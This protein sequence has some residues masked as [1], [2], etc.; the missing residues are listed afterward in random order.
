[1]STKSVSEVIDQDRRQL[2]TNAAMGIAAAGA[3]SIFPA[4]R[5]NA[6]AE[7]RNPSVPR[8]FSGR[9]AGR[10]AQTCK[11]D[12]VAQPGKRQGCNA[13]RAIR[14][15]AEA[16]TVLGD[17]LRLAQD[18]VQAECVAAVHHRDRWDRHSFHSYPLEARECFA[19]GRHAWMAGF[20]HRAIEDYRS[21]Y[22]SQRR[23]ARA[24]R[25]PSIS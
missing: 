12:E 13:G 6:A 11:R 20:D 22:R 21:T 18:R 23:T 25:T 15:H 2:L 17:G 3:A 9:G 24:R 14:D 8:P 1:M 5:S 7:R 4:F 16:R 10:S 19:D